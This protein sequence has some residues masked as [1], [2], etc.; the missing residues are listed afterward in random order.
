MHLLSHDFTM[1]PL[2][3]T[4]SII[5]ILQLTTTLVNYLTGVKGASE[6]QKRYTIEASQLYTLLLNL[7]YRLEEATPTSPW[8]ARA[9]ELGA[10][11]GPLSQ[12]KAALERLVD[13]VVPKDGARKIASRVLWP[14]NKAEVAEI[15]STIERLK[16]LTSIA[17]EMDHL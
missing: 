15:F 11:N 2:S 16:S 6:D 7:K 12:Y 9:R 4:A 13:K 3:T 1:D 17:L 10:E 8:Y 5:A 14:F